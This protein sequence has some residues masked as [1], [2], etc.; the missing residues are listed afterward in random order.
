MNLTPELINQVA[1]L[2]RLKL[3]ATTRAHLVAQ[4][5]RVFK[6]IE[7]LNE[8]RRQ[9]LESLGDKNFS[10]KAGDF[11]GRAD[12]VTPA[13]WPLVEPKDLVKAAPAH[14]NNYLSVPQVF[15]RAKKGA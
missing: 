4:L 3:T 11:V 5:P 7:S 6:F 14:L 1:T 10:A 2:S 8:A 13:P 9:G 15:K 12:E